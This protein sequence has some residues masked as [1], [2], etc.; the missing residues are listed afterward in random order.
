M[1]D[2]RDRLKA[3]QQQ[4]D[5]L[6]KDYQALIK[7]YESSDLV[8]ENEALKK[9]NKENKLILAELGAQVLKLRRD[10]SELQTALTEQILDEKLGILRVSRQKLQ[11]YFASQSNAYLDRLTSFEQ[12]IRRRIEAMYRKCSSELGQDQTEIAGML[13]EV[14]LKLNESI[15][16]R[17]QW[18][19]EAE[20]SL[21]GA[22][23]SRHD[24]F[25]AEGVSEETLQRRRKQ[26][27]IEMKIGLNWI[28]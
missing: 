2:F 15:V 24:I 28:N 9:E 22:M 25:A 6:L 19:R 11:T 14:Q 3:V 5:G 12:E 20:Q 8:N 21:R 10:N 1:E 4:Q 23:D 7:E 16:L 18:Q 26:N 17:R 13:G 27:R